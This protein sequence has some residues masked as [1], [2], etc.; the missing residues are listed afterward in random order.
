MEGGR[1]M[2]N[3]VEATKRANVKALN[4][5]ALRYT[6]VWSEE[7]KMSI[8]DEDEKELFI[9]LL[10]GDDKK[11]KDKLETYVFGKEYLWAT[12]GGEPDLEAVLAIKLLGKIR[13]EKYYASMIYSEE[14]LI[15]VGIKKKEKGDVKG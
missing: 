10:E 5:T 1:N 3:N 8:I 9:A 11:I 14:Y 15:H 2:T 12:N 4:H 6:L 7:G 13:G